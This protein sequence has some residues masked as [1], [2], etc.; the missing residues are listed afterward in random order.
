LLELTEMLT[1]DFGPS[2]SLSSLSSSVMWILGEST[3]ITGGPPIEIEGKSSPGKTILGIPDCAMTGESSKVKVG[4]GGLESGGGLKM[5]GILL[6]SNSTVDRLLSLSSFGPRDR[7]LA[8]MMSSIG[9]AIVTCGA[10]SGAALMGRGDAARRIS[11]E[12]T[13]TDCLLSCVSFMSRISFSRQLDDSALAIRIGGLDGCGESLVL[14]LMLL[15][16]EL[17]SVVDPSL[18]ESILLGA[19]LDPALRFL[20]RGGPLAMISSAAIRT[21]SCRLRADESADTIFDK[22]G[23]P[24]G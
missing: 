21:L 23:G 16:G 9:A 5:I 4:T 15:T 11:L 18:I 10:G 3:S 13:S 7:G 19:N 1:L 17:I 20:R 8:G 24:G 14:P 12:G 22:G 6:A 2:E